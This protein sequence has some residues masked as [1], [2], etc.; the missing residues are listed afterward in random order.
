M[1]LMDERKRLREDYPN[2]ISRFKAD[3]EAGSAT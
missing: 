2:L 3:V 1:T